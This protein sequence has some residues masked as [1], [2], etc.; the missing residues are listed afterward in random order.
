MNTTQDINPKHTAIGRSGCG[1]TAYNIAKGLGWLYTGKPRLDYGCGLG[2]EADKWNVDKLDKYQ[3]EDEKIRLT[4]PYGDS[5]Q[6]HRMQ[7]AFGWYKHVICSCVLNTIPNMSE[8]MTVIANIYNLLETGGT[9]LFTVYA[10]VPKLDSKA[11]GSAWT[12]FLDGWRIDCED[13]GK[14]VHFQTPYSNTRIQNLIR[15]VLSD[16][17][18]FVSTGKAGA[19]IMRKLK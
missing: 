4:S 8:R 9:A 6:F 11:V 2:E 12:R 16:S 7:D 3:W 18:S 1:S 15:D 19:V 5:V 13:I 14:G 10:G 17:V